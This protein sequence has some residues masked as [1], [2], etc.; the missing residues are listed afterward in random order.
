MAQIPYEKISDFEK[1]MLF[2]AVREEKREAGEDASWI[3]FNYKMLADPYKIDGELVKS[4][5][6]FEKALKNYV[7][8]GFTIDVVENEALLKSFRGTKHERLVRD[9]G[10]ILGKGREIN[11]G[12][13]DTESV[14]RANQ[15]ASLL[16]RFGYEAAD[17]EKPEPKEV[18]GSAEYQNMV[19][20]AFVAY[21]AAR[22]NRYEPK[23]GDKIVEACIDY[24]KGK[25]SVR[26]TEYGRKRFDDSLHLMATFADPNDAKVRVNI[27]RINQVRKTKPGERN[28][29]D[30][31]RYGAEGSIARTNAEL[32]QGT[33]AKA[34]AAV[35]DI[36]T[37]S[38]A[39]EAKEL[40]MLKNAEE[41]RAAYCSTENKNKRALETTKQG[42]DHLTDVWAR[43]IFKNSPS[44][45]ASKNKPEGELT[46]ADV[47]CVR[48]AQA[49]V[50]YRSLSALTEKHVMTTDP[51]RTNNEAKN[52]L[53]EQFKAN[54]SLAYAT[55]RLYKPDDR[56]FK[57]DISSA[58]STSQVMQ[59]YMSDDMSKIDNLG[60]SLLRMDGSPAKIL[61]NL[62][63]DAMVNMDTAYNTADPTGYVTGRFKKSDDFLENRPMTRGEHS[64]NLLARTAEATTQ[65]K[66]L[67]EY[68][69]GGMPISEDMALLRNTV[70]YYCVADK[71]M[72]YMYPEAAS[73]PDM[74]KVYKKVDAMLKK[75]AF[76]EK[77]SVGQPDKDFG[78]RIETLCM[79]E[80][81]L[82]KKAGSI[83]V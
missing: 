10:E 70:A 55:M 29:V 66:K 46:A 23:M 12:I 42:R 69:P 3:Q 13:S 21:R 34:R 64:E 5:L 74:N 20:T 43:E 31:A 59:L 48:L 82:E 53:F 27:D 68:H 14:K 79:E 58:T 37:G 30:L 83:H 9:V 71:V 39:Q 77:I 17:L 6:G 24:N 4:Q 38:G 80:L 2:L 45:D 61:E 19:K 28:Y 47:V 15:L 63:S 26:M 50:A 41:K 33:R 35:A 78:S 54:I 11:K 7:E 57:H 75:P 1:V 18:S 51:K 49:Y 65:Y 72:T 36:L 40:Y 76:A 25:K 8:G 22:E 32:L 67:A 81:T 73:V 62:N 16:K 52:D 60:G 44:L 56:M